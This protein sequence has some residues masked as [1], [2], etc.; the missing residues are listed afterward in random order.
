MKHN[1]SHDRAADKM[2]FSIALERSIVAEINR[3]AHAEGRNR[4]QQI[5]W[6]LL[7]SLGERAKARALTHATLREI[8]GSAPPPPKWRSSD[9][10]SGASTHTKKRI[11]PDANDKSA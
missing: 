8:E 6:M 5:R 4:N 7:E 1:K 2:G 3:Y 10:E 9:I 11:S